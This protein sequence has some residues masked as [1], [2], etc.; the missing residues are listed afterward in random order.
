L[1]LFRVYNPSDSCKERREK[2]K[3]YE[4]ESIKASERQREF[5]ILKKTKKKWWW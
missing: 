5:E 2:K 4:R 1:E 3:H